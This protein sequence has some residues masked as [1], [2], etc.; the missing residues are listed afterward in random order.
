MKMDLILKWTS[1]PLAKKK[2]KNENILFHK[3]TQGEQAF[4]RK[5]MLLENFSPVFMNNRM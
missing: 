4:Q 1:R 3:I 5:T 2:K